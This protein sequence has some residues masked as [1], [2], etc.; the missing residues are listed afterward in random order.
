LAV[1]F[2]AAKVL[3]TDRTRQSQSGN[4]RQGAM[5]AWRGAKQLRRIRVLLAG[6]PRMLMDIVKNIVVSQEDFDL[7]G[8]ISGRN[9]LLQAATDT[10]ADVVVVGGFAA[11]ELKIYQDLL[12]GRP[13]L[14]IVAIA[15]DGRNAFL[16]ELQPH[17]I[18]LGEVAPAS[19]IA[20]I[21]NAPHTDGASPITRQ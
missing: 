19:L 2:I 11:T 21:R 4:P 3:A 12:Y 17:L 13:L 9:G 20:A 5:T 6:M 18:P 10:Q 7:A 14:R 16:H 8:E 1:A 15:A